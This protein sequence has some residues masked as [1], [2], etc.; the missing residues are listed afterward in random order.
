MLSPQ[1]GG[2]VLVYSL[3]N[4]N[5]LFLDDAEQ[6]WKPGSRVVASAGRFD[7]GPE[8]TIPKRTKLW[9]GDWSGEITGARS[10]RLTSPKDSSTGVQLIRDF[11]LGEES[12]ELTCRQTIMNVSDRTVE[13]CHWSRT[14]ATGEGICVIPLSQPTRFPE[15]HVMYESGGVINFRN[16][17]EHIRVRDGFLEITAAPRRPKLGFDSTAGW[18][19]YVTRDDLL[20]VNGLR[21]FPTGSTTKQPHSQ[22]QS[23]TLLARG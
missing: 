23:G 19:A 21:R 14:F 5:A 2:R 6:N 13:W 16:R 17:D 4:R 15:N 7:I 9:A 12:S 18:M 3:G 8:L 22:F 10:A 1:A 11:S 20:F